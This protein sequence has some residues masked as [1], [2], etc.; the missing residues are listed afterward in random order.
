LQRVIN[1]FPSE[2]QGN[3]AAQM[4]D[5]LIGVVSQRL[6]FRPNL[7]IC[8][9]ECEVLMATLAVKN[10]IRNRDFFKIISSIETGAEYGMW[11]YPR[12]RAWLDKRTHFNIAARE[13]VAEEEETPAKFRPLPTAMPKSGQPGRI[14]EPAT[15][16]SAKSTAADPGRIEIE[17]TE[18]FEK[19]L[20]PPS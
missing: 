6:Q 18:N 7:N 5:C 4:A 1:S 19:I 14:T 8:V 3:V 11:S 12:Y 20:K 17:P 2:I 10:F 9:P 13:T 16:V 15:G